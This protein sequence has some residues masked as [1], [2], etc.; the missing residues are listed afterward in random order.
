MTTQYTRGQTLAQTRLYRAVRRVGLAG[1]LSPA[2]LTPGTA[3]FTITGGPVH[4]YALFGHVTTVIGAG[5]ATPQLAFLPTGGGAISDLCAAAASIATV[6]VNVLLT[7]T[8]LLAGLLT[9][10]VGVGHLDLTGAEGGFAAPLT[11]TAGTIRLINATDA[12]SGVIDWYIVYLPF[13][14]ATVITA[15]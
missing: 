15:A 3:L 12:V 11:M 9:P 2:H 6:A 5:L 10:G 7:W 4:V 13:A 8:G 14:D 1:D